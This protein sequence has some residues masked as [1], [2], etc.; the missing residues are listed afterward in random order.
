VLAAALFSAPARAVDGLAEV[1]TQRLFDAVQA[2]D[3]AAVQASVAAGAS[4]DARDRW[5]MSAIELAIDKGY[6]AIAHFLTSAR[7]YRR[8]AGAPEGAPA[9]SAGQ[10]AQPPAAMQPPA[11]G[12]RAVPSAVP[13]PS[14]LQARTTAPRA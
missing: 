12:K 5:G 11:G 4:L 7:Q 8:Q 14:S 1:Q 3:L 13:R 10:G 9:P 6:F 2:N